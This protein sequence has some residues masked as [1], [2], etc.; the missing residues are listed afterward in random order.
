[1]IN[2]V[3]I[4]VP[5]RVSFVKATYKVYMSFFAVPVPVPVAG[6]GPRFAH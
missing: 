5:I 6:T 3:K 4:H 1:M 2:G